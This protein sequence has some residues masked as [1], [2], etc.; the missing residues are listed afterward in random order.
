MWIL[1]HLTAY[2]Y[3]RADLNGLR[4]N[5]GDIPW[6]DIFKRGAFVVATEFCGWVQVGIDVYIPH[7]EYQGKPHISRW[8]LAACATAIFHRNYFIHV[9]QENKS[10]SKVKFRKDC[11]F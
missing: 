6:E 3:P 2:D 9:Y 5:L 11:N 4:E 7:L 8:F 1:F 10:A